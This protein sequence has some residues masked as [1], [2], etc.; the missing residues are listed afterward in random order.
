MTI[1]RSWRSF[2]SGAAK[3]NSLRVDVGIALSDVVVRRAARRLWAVVATWMSPVR[4]VNV[5]H[6]HNLGV[7]TSGS[8]SFDPHGGPK[9]WFSQAAMTFF[10][11]RP[12]ACVRP[13]V[14]V[15]PSPAGVAVIAVV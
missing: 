12:R 15:F 7:T 13:M 11:K 1:F 4:L 6:G 9:G 2:I 5:L 14:H 3:H 8:P 10:P